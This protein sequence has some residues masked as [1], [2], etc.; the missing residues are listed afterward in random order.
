MIDFCMYDRLRYISV[1]AAHHMLCVLL[2]F[3]LH[4]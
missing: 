4:T 1:E 3:A 2:S